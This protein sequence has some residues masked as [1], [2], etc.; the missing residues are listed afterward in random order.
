MTAGAQQSAAEDT[1]AVFGRILVPVSFNQDSHQAIHVALEL[2]SM[3]GAK[4]CVFHASHGSEGDGFLA[5]I[6]SPPSSGDLVTQAREALERLV[7]NIEPERK[8]G[9]EYDA[10]LE[11]DFVDAIRDKAQEWGATLVVLSHERYKSILRT[12]SEKLVKELPVPALILQPGA[13]G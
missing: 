13:G 1:A 5:G 11:S 3:S 10:T 4:V 8:Q 12:P 6:G 7:G 2:S 9:V